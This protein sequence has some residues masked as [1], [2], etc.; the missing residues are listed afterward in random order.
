MD[1]CE[2]DCTRTAFSPG[3]LMAWVRARVWVRVR[4]R[5]RVGVRG[6][7]IEFEGEGQDNQGVG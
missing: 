1:C 3:A 5:V 2:W 6:G 4:V 7:K